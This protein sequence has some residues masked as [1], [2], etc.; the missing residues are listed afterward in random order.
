[1]SAQATPAFG[2]P[3]PAEAAAIVSPIGEILRDITR[4]GL[5]GAIVGVLVAGVGGRIVMRLAALLVPAATGLPT[6]NGNRIGEITLTG[7]LTLVLFGLI[8]GLIGGAIWVVVSPWIPGARLRRAILTMP[9]AVGV[10]GTGLIEGSNPDFF[11]L[12]H[13]PVVVG[14]LIALVALVGFAIA[15]VD[16]WLGRRLPHPALGRRGVAGIYAAVAFV[17]AVLIALPTV[18]GLLG[19]SDP[20]T[21]LRALTLLA[22]AI[23]TIAWWADRIRGRT[24]SARLATAGRVALVVAVIVGFAS[25]IPEIAG[26]LGIA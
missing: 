17:G 9:I 11:V 15:M 23:C 12:R 10:V 20:P 6:E 13:D 16:S 1:M 18:L 3:P 4:G 14:L 24:M 2:G 22:V 8:A 19:S 25:T 5:A 7:S 21:F 26:A